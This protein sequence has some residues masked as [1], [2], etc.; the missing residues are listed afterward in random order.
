MSLRA[1]ILA[2][3]DSLNDKKNLEIFDWKKT[4]HILNLGYKMVQKLR[5]FF[6]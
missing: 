6:L 2:T 4:W 5:E 1:I 3:T